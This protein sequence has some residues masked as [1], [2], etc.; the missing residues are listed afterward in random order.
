[1]FTYTPRQYG[2]MCLSL[3]IHV[4]T[5]VRDYL[6]VLLSTFSNCSSRVMLWSER[7]LNN[8]HFYG[9]YS[10]RGVEL[11]D[12]IFFNKKK[13]SLGPEYIY[14]KYYEIAIII[15]PFLLIDFVLATQICKSINETIVEVLADLADLESQIF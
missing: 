8:F 1:M 3:Y 7:I 9:F 13:V 5:A 15:L 4:Y 12:E 11:E 14:L 10:K 2:I 6:S